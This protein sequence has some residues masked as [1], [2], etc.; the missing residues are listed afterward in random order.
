MERPTR[1]KG[2]VVCL[3]GIALLLLGCALFGRAPRPELPAWRAE[4]I[5]AWEE[6]FQKADPRWKGG[7]GASSVPVG[8]SKTLWLFGDTWITKPDAEGRK[9]AFL[10]RNSLAVQ[11]LKDGEPGRIDFFWNER[12]GKPA[13]AFPSGGDPGWLWPLSGVR[14][15][16]RLILFFVRCVEG[17]SPLGFDLAGS[18]L[19]TVLNPDEP[20]PQW[21]LERSPV[22]FFRHADQGDSFF[23]VCCLLAEGSLYVYGVREDW[24]R[25]PEGRSVLVARAPPDADAVTDF[26]AWR[27]FDGRQWVTDWSRAAPLFDGGATEMSVSWLPGLGRYTAVYTRWGLS[28]LI[29]ARTSLVPE[30]PWSKPAVLYRCPDVAWNSRYFTYAGKAHPELARSGRELI[31]TYAT[32]STEEE[33]H[34]G[35]LRIYW[36]RFVRATV[37]AS[38]EASARDRP[39]FESQRPPGRP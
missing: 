29:L 17:S 27:F 13:D 38:P 32:N 8:D 34:L 3:A 36:P 2:S 33:D 22:P 37:S 18:L 16:S 19:L 26:H 24:G 9:G 30:G 35:D 12:D 7:D 5:L 31:V 4:P 1:R 21:R 23:G 25:G 14:I 10:I 28:D 20:P 15:G 6:A 11:R 39:A